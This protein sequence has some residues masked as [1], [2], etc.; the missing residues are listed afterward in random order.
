[1]SGYDPTLGAVEA[2]QRWK[3]ALHAM[4]F[5]Q[6]E[7][8]EAECHYNIAIDLLRQ[9]AAEPSLIDGKGGPS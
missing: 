5:A 7:L 6:A 9:T 8:G 3:K 2:W 4:D 1:M